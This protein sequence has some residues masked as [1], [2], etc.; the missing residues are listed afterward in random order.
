[1][2]RCVRVALWCVTKV[3][4]FCTRKLNS[5]SDPILEARLPRTFFITAGNGTG[6]RQ[7]RVTAPRHRHPSLLGSLPERLCSMKPLSLLPN[8]AHCT[9]HGLLDTLYNAG[10]RVIPW[11]HGAL[12][13]G[14]CLLVPPGAE[15]GLIRNTSCSVDAACESTW[16][17]PAPP[18]PV[19]SLG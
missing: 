2:G 12:E 3:D 14:L 4:S 16:V 18:L 9:S 15:P 5:A 10:T 13:A 1:M 6:R 19:A 11:S 17:V 8:P 7:R